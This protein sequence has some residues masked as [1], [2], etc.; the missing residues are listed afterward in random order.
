[1]SVNPIR[2]DGTTAPVAQGSP[3]QSGQPSLV[4]PA[5]RQ[6]L[7]LHEHER[8]LLGAINYLRNFR[9]RFLSLH[10]ARGTIE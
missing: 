2:N 8:E 6:S 5:E 9:L 4:S 3:A 7:P 1:M 10:V